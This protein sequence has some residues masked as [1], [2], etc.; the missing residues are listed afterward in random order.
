MLTKELLLVREVKNY[1]TLPVAR[2]IPLLAA[3]FIFVL[4]SV[5]KASA[6]MT[7]S[8]DDGD[9][10]LNGPLLIPIG[11]KVS[12]FITI[13]DNCPMLA[14]PKQ[15][16]YDGDGIG[17]LCDNDD[18]GDGIVDTD[19]DNDGLGDKADLDDDGDGIVDSDNDNDGLGDRVDTDDDNDGLPDVWE[20]K[21]GFNPLKA[22]S[23][24]DNDHD[25]LTN[26]QEY[27]NNSNPLF[28][29]LGDNKN[30]VEYSYDDFGRLVEVIYNNGENYHYEYDDVGN[31]LEQQ[32]ARDN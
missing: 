20:L 10:V 18:N 19:Y 5:P 7:N 32:H 15:S 16:D 30:L 23:E 17:D 12:F 4:I 13:K 3:I 1:W 9:G 31:R 28:P 26:L 29:D 14:N 2:L 25:G 22:D 11:I 21:F 27:K 6:M 8:D 24:K